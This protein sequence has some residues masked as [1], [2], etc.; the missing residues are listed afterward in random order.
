MKIL[1]IILTTLTFQWSFAHGVHD[2]GEVKPQKGGI[3]KSLET[4]HVELVQLDNEL[5]VYIFDKNKEPKTIPTGKHPVYANLKLP[6]VKKT[7]KVELINKQ[8]YWSYTYTKKGLRPYKF[9][10]SI[11]Q[12]GHKDNLAF[13]IKP[14]RVNPKK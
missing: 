10:F 6:R 8:D 9:I 4:V 1:I 5:R 2:S 13:T 7:E 11:E 14:K 12:G 3:L